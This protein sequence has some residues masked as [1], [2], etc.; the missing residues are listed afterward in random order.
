MNSVTLFFCSLKNLRAS[1][2]SCRC[3][4][5]YCDAGLHGTHQKVEEVLKKMNTVFAHL[6]QGWF[7]SVKLAVSVKTVDWLPQS[8]LVGKD[9]LLQA[10]AVLPFSLSSYI[11]FSVAC[12]GH[13]YLGTTPPLKRKAS[14]SRSQS[15]RRDRHFGVISFICNPDR[16]SVAT[17]DIQEGLLWPLAIG[18]WSGSDTFQEMPINVLRHKYAEQKGCCCCAVAWSHLLITYK[19]PTGT[20]P[21]PSHQECERPRGHGVFLIWLKFLIFLSELSYHIFKGV[22][23]SGPC[24][25]LGM[26]LVHSCRLDQNHSVNW[27]YTFFIPSLQMYLS[28]QR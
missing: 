11:F 24:C 13:P 22:S 7:G 20:G 18:R 25:I 9:F 4:F 16:L 6:P 14:V 15:T 17:S 5:C 26:L 8:D 23:L 3:R 2:T 21:V 12:S 27:R 1:L 28:S 10:A 19:P